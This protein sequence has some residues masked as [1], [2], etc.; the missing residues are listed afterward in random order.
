VIQYAYRS[1]IK[2]FKF[3]PVHT[4]A[5]RY[6]NY[7]IYRPGYQAPKKKA[8][9]P[10]SQKFYSS[11][12]IVTLLLIGSLLGLYFFQAKHTQAIEHKAQIA[13]AA[14]KAQNRQSFILEVQKIIDK[15]P[16][17]DISVSAADLTNASSVKVG[18]SGAMDAASCGKVLT[19]ALFL[20]DVE[21]GSESLSDKLGGYTARYQLQQLIQQSDDNAWLLLNDELGHA[22]LDAYAQSLGLNSYDPDTN[23]IKSADMTA[24]LQ[25]LYS[26]R[27]LNQAHTKLLLT[28]MQNTNYED[29]ISQALPQNYQLYHKVGF[30]DGEINDAAIITGGRSKIVISIFTNNPKSSDGTDT[31]ERAALIQNITKAAILYLN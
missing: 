22:A 16:N 6:S 5:R 8:P 25:K 7:Y 3:G 27:L 26:G 31:A 12:L 9:T 18:K 17:V 21:K 28:F 19:A 14:Q 1:K 13:E 2:S 24:L 11:K 20:H 23:F 30:V 15:N 29:F 10:K 4:V